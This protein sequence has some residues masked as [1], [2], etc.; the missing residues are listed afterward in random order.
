M[1]EY[2]FFRKLSKQ[3]EQE[4]RDWAHRNYVIGDEIPSSWHP[5]VV[6]ECQAMIAGIVKKEAVRGVDCKE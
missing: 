1:N 4:F 3:E 2:K 5:V 6:D